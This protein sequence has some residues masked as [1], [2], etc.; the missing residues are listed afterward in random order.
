VTSFAYNPLYN[1]AQYGAA[2]CELTNLL[3]NGASYSVSSL[4]FIDVCADRGVQ[5]L[6]HYVYGTSLLVPVVGA[7]LMLINDPHIECVFEELQLFRRTSVVQ[8]SS[9]FSELRGIFRT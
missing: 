6:W 7:I 5:D 3:V 8:D 9:V 4:S 1:T 2:G